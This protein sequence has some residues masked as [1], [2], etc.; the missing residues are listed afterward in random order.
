M[1]YLHAVPIDDRRGGEREMDVK[2]E[3]GMER[4]PPSIIGSKEVLEERG[5][6]YGG[7]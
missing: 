1:G 4:T 7:G 5:V 2:V 3:A 6:V